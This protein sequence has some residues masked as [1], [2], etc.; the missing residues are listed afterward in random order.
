MLQRTQCRTV[1]KV[2]TSHQTV[3]TVVLQVVASIPPVFLL[4][5]SYNQELDIC[6]W[7]ERW[8]NNV[9]KAVNKEINTVSE[10]MG[11]I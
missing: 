7:Q 4:T 10:D 6:Y 3:S 8:D 5:Q 9:T 1:T 2:A 11:T